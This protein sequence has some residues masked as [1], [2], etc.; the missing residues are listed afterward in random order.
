MSQD[1]QR[2]TTMHDH[3]RATP[4]T[5]HPKR[6]AIPGGD[7]L[8]HAVGQ[9]EQLLRR[10]QREMHRVIA[11]DQRRSRLTHPQQQAMMV[12]VDSDQSEGM[13]LK[14]LS[15]RMGLGHSTVSGIVD[16]LER[17][18]LLRRQADAADRRYVRIQVTERVREYMRERLPAHL[19]GPLLDAL[20]RATAADQTAILTG[21]TT[22]HRLLAPGETSD[23]E[24][25]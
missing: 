25:S 21:L 15:E 14:A 22:L 9:I 24:G 13:T 6:D 12:L 23:Q 17:Q 8:L 3:S 19:H 7:D 16:R 18:G 1:Q 2:A 20:R 10:I 5:E 11:D 4:T